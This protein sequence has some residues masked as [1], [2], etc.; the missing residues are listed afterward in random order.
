[1]NENDPSKN[2]IRPWEV[3]NGEDVGIGKGVSRAPLMTEEEAKNRPK[4]IERPG[5]NFNDHPED[6]DFG[7]IF[8]KR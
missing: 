8:G 2:T 5:T 7:P 1:M 3:R 4:P 6:Y